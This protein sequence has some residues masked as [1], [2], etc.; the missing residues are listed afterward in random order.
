MFD[1]NIDLI[2]IDLEYF[3]MSLTQK[4]YNRV[5]AVFAGKQETLN[6]FVRGV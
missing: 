4:K 1:M 3:R 5:Y 6:K 2:D